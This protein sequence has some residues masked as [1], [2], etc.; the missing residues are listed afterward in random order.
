ME[1]KEECVCVWGGGGMCFTVLAASQ[2]GF[3][4]SCSNAL[5]C[6]ALA[7]CIAY[8]PNTPNISTKLHD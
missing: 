6:A 2:V 3:E 8:T 5:S 1:G 4:F 7:A